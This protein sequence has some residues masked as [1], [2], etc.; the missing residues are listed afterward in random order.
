MFSTLIFALTYFL[1]YGLFL[2]SYVSGQNNFQKPLTASE[3]KQYLELA[4]KG[5]KGAK[6]VLVERNLRLVAHIAKK[7]TKI[8]GADDDDLISIG[9]IGL[10]KAISTFDYKKQARLSTYAARCIENEI[11]M[12]VRGTK[13]LKQEVSLN[14]CLGHDS[15]GN[16]VTFMDILPACDEDVADRVSTDMDI[17]KL[18]EYIKKCL[19]PREQEIIIKRYGLGKRSYTQ[20]EIARSMKISRSYVSRIEKKA[21][22]ALNQCYKE[23]K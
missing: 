21:L 3:E 7:Y 6:D 1:Q 14:E 13:K 17:G 12:S 16:E 18:G 22:D 11:L 10:I 23:N 20:Q 8:A 4:S 2:V 19:T 9:T 5:D 15:D